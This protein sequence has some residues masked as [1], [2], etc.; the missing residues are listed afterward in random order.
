MGKCWK[1]CVAAFTAVF[2]S[3]EF[4]SKQEED[5][6]P[7][8]QSPLIEGAM[9]STSRFHFMWQAWMRS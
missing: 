7:P 6:L 4:V 3:A 8:L 1:S 9:M 5:F 2:D